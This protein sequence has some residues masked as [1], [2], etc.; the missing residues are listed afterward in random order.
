MIET[1]ISYGFNDHPYFE[2]ENRY[3]TKNIPQSIQLAVW[4]YEIWKNNMDHIVNQIYLNSVSIKAVHLPLNT[5]ITPFQDIADLMGVAISTLLCNKFIIHPNKGIE[6][7]IDKFVEW[8]ET[9]TI[10]IENF[11]YKKKKVLRNP[12]EIINKCV[13]LNSDKVKMCLDT[14]HAEG[15]WF[16][17]CIM[18]TILKYTGV[19]HLSNRVGKKSH[20]PFNMQNGDLNLVGFVNEL[21]KKYK[22]EGLIV[23][24]YLPHYHYKLDSNLKYLNRLVQ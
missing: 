1:A 24:E 3:H 12:I 11:R 22:W 19:I 14:S 8:S 10:Y 20:L 13:E 21:K 2:D 6:E 18:P 5:L 4:Q 7:F 15:V 23:L 17:N 16:D 9:A